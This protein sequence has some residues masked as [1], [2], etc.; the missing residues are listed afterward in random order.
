M[1]RRERG[2]LGIEIQIS[3]LGNLIWHLP[4]TVISVRDGRNKD[5]IYSVARDEPMQPCEDFPIQK[6]T[7]LI[8]VWFVY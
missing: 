8:G 4:V 5:M 2:E 1:R 7:I 6:L 3:D